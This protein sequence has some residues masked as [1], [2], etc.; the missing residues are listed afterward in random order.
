MKATAGVFG[1]MMIFAAVASGKIPERDIGFS[2]IPE[3]SSA[4]LD[5]VY[6]ATIVDEV[7]WI[8]L[9]S[10][11]HPGTDV[12]SID[13]KQRMVVVVSLGNPPYSGTDLVVTRVTRLQA[14]GIRTLLVKVYV[15]ERRPGKD[16]VVI[17][18]SATSYRLIET[19]RSS[20]VTFRRTTR[21]VPC[22]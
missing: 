3:P 8:Q 20:D 15:D 14:V 11:L 18:P 9:W 7:H 12:P 13:F 22:R 19:E 16:C 17:E 21:Y 4:Y 1:L 6:D 5:D 10:Q 2:V